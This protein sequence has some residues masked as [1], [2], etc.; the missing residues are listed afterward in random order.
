LGKTDLAV[1]AVVSGLGAFLA[2]GSPVMAMRAA[3]AVEAEVIHLVGGGLACTL[4]KRSGQIVDLKQMAA[5]DTFVSAKFGPAGLEVFDELERKWY[6]DL[7]TPSQVTDLVANTY[8]TSFL[9]QFEGAPF[10]LRCTWRP[11]G[12]GLRLYVEAL[13]HEGAAQRSIRISVVLPATPHLASWAPSWPAPSD[14]RADPIRYCYLADEAGKARTGIPMLTLF[15][16]GKGGLS[17]CMPFEV[18]KVQLNMGVEPFDPTKWYVPET[19]PRLSAGA[20]VDTVT[21][22]DKG[23]M[24]ERLVIRFT[25]KHVGLRPGKTLPFAMWLFGH[26]PDW[27]PALGTVVETY[28][29]YF[30]PHPGFAALAGGTYGANP[31]R[32]APEM[33]AASRPFGYTKNWF[34]AHFE[35]HGEFLTDQ[36]C[37]DP[38]YRWVCEPYPKEFV[39]LGVDRV[40]KGIHS[41]RAIGDATFVY[42]FNMHCDET[43]IRKRHLDADVGRNQKGDI[44]RAYHEQPVMYFSP[45][46]PFGRHQLEQMDR[47]MK[48]YPEIAGVALDNWNYAGIDFGHDDGITMVN[49]QPAANLNF[50]QQRMI[51][52]IAAKMHA[53]GRFVFTNKGRTIES[54]RGV[55]TVLTEA[56]GHETYGTFAYMNLHRCVTPC[57]YE[58]MA[59]AKYAEYVLKYVLVWGGQQSHFEAQSDPE[60]SQA[61]KPLYDCIRNQRWVFTPDPLTL[62]PGCQGQIFRIDQRSPWNAGT[63]AV[64]LVRQDVSWRDGDLKAGLNVKVRLPDGERY[65]KAYWI[66][67]ESGGKDPVE[68]MIR[69]EKGEISVV[70][71]PVGAAGVMQLVP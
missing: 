1:V 33:L 36:A 3:V 62:P 56:H 8:E 13:L 45:E 68:C 27:R 23:D 66:G 9:K 10:S 37:S 12:D 35:F 59:D 71:P 57:E 48:I 52:A 19:V 5:Q 25:E 32:V 69:R 40:R 51:P 34:H 26:A 21:P 2:A 22:P 14:V 41:L 30:E 44:A 16:P 18:P 38:A 11:T 58:S 20:E 70:L 39:D 17:L 29:D 46:S 4:D 47:L 24:G 64:T 43:I 67:V 61:Y 53:T 54:F 63:V 7:K 55:D 42:G 60:Q 28:K 15:H 65:K 31:N 6:T 49:N 50:S